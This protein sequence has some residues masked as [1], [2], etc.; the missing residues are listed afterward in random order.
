MANKKK[1]S[2]KRAAGRAHT[3]PTSSQAAPIAAAPAAPTT[4]SITPT[5]AVPKS[6]PAT[7][8][9]AADPRW[10]Y[11]G[12]DVRRT[13]VI[14]AACVALELVLWFLLNHTGIGPSIY[15]LIKL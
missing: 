10:G 8:A 3:R 13:A 2:K 15:H 1:K 6:K 9:A 14:A 4:E 7:A 12:R 5:A 11:V